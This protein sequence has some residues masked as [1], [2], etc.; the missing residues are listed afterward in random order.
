MQIFRTD[1]HPLPLPAGHRFPAEKYRL[2]REAVEAFAPHLIVDA[3]AASDAELLHAHTADYIARLNAGALSAAEERAIGLPWSAELVTR[4]RYSTG[5]TLAACR[6][7]LQQGCGVSLAGGTHHAYA[8][9]GSGFCVFNDSAVALRVLH[10]EGVINRAL[11]L[12]LDVHQGNGTAA[13]LADAP[14]LFTFS[15][16]GQNNFP[17]QKEHSDWDIEL[18]DGTGDADYLATLAGALPRLL[19][20]ARPDL[21][22]YLAG[23]DPYAGDRL[24]KL[25]L[26][27]DGLAQRDAMVLDACTRFGLP[28][29][30]TMGGGYATPISDTVQIQT[31][32]VRQA[33]ARFG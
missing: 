27:M 26:S 14:E 25:S 12:D 21:I 31:Q 2:L 22:I 5:A 20:L 4:S 17:F 6:T 8:E 30:I 18:A 16:H 1:Q 3:P 7:A 29:A 33:W 19:E 10:A 13:M 15:M 32:T 24:G 28:V 23:A 11:V 9:R